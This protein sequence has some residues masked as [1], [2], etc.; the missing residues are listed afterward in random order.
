MVYS[1]VEYKNLRLIRREQLILVEIGK[2]K[3]NSASGFVDYMEEVYGFSK[4]STW[5]NL[6]RMKEKGFIEFATKDSPGKALYLTNFGLSHLSALNVY[7]EHLM[8]DFSPK[9][10]YGLIMERANGRF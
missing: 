6:N 7:K 5:Y 8:K 3:I 9:N 2:D 10:S 1:S 4:S